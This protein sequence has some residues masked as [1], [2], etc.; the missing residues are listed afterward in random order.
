[1]PTFTVLTDSIGDIDTS[2]QLVMFEGFQKA[3]VVNGTNLKVVD[4]VNTKLTHSALA[5]AHAKGDVLTQATSNATMI[6]DF[7]NSAKTATYGYVTSGTFNAVNAVTGSGSGSGFT[8]SAVTSPNHWYDWTVYPGG[9]SGSMPSEAYLG[10]LY[11]GRCVLS[12]NSQNP[13]QWYMSRVADPWDWLYT[14]NDALS[15][16]AGGN[17]QAGKMG[18]IIKALIPYRDEYLIFGC[19]HSFWVLKGDPAAGGTIQLVD[20][21]KGIF[22]AWAHC[23]D[24]DGNL[25]F[26]SYDGLYVMPFGFGPIVPLTQF[27]LPDL[28]SEEDIET[29]THRVSLGYDKYQQGIVL[30]MTN[31]TTGANKNY[32]YSL[33]TKGFF[34]EVYPNSCG[35]FSMLPYDADDTE[36]SGLLLGCTDGYIRIHDED[37]KSDATT[38]STEAIDAYVTLPVLHS[39]DLTN[40]VKLVSS[41]VTLAGGASSGEFSDTDAVTLEIYKGNDPETVIEDIF[42]GATPLHSI[43]LTGTGRKNRIRNRTKGNAIALRFRNNTADST[44]ALEAVGGDLRDISRY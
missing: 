5:T 16:V 33:Q 19:S 21:T 12:G 26:A 15:P 20:N 25:Y 24:P 4:T 35:V 43:D 27:V 18:D 13:E 3:F 17:T 36:D 34:P 37:T 7:T 29:D 8:P 39:E 31:M 41:S 30:T 28:F 9:S 38:V 40:D 23:F 22:G 11:R 10:C 44:F 42:D 14:A 1:M 2:D 32:F 6:V